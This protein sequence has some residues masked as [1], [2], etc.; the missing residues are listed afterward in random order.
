MN[1]RNLLILGASG[2]FFGSARAQSKKPES[3]EA[4][5]DIR[6]FGAVGDGTHDDTNAFQRAIDYAC[7]NKMQLVIPGT[8][9]SYLI[10]DSLPIPHGKHDWAIS[11]EAGRVTITQTTNNKPIFL[12]SSY[13]Q[14]YPDTTNRSFRVSNL[15]AAWTR[16]PCAAR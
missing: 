13:G 16:S 6:K 1:R 3:I 2:G 12:F 15:R 11:G 4:R 8:P 7:N 5:L 14:D 9:R 10:S